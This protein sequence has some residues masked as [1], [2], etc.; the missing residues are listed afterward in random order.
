MDKSRADDVPPCFYFCGVDE[1]M[2]RKR[3]SAMASIAVSIMV[4]G[5]FAFVYGLSSSVNVIWRFGPF[6]SEWREID[7]CLFGALFAS[8]GAGL[9]TFAAL[10]WPRRDVLP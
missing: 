1:V 8:V 10:N 6:Y 2:M 4:A 9:L 3:R 5:I 7:F